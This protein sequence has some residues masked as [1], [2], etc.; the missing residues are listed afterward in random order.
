[1]QTL[2]KIKKASVRTAYLVF[3][4]L[5]TILG[6]IFILFLLSRVMPIDPVL[7]VVGDNASHETYLAAKAAL[8]FDQPFYKQFFIY[9]QQIAKGDL[10]KSLMTSH[11]V[12][13]DLLRVFPA[14]IELGATALLIG[15]LFGIP[16]G[17][18]AAF[19]QN[20]WI[21]KTIDLVTLSGYSIPT[22]WFALICLLL[23]YYHWGILPGIG[24]IDLIYKDFEPTTNFIFFDTLIAGRMDVFFNAL[25]HL[26]LPAGVLGFFVMAYI[27]R[28]T[29]AFTI[30]ELNQQYI[31][32]AK[33]KG[34]S[35]YY[36]VRHVFKNIRAPLVTL[37]ALS[38]GGLLE[39]AVLTETIFAWPGLGLYLTQALQS[40]D[41]NAI[42][43]AVLLIGII[44]MGINLLADMM[45]KFL[46]VRIRE[47]I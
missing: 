41:M 2:K 28:M 20:R 26:I 46:D 30:E 5:A 31:L 39:G 18:L 40:L 38:H 9:F 45:N 27:I 42:L 6:I 12:G 17:I 14:T 47:Y 19:R 32:T 23:F 1:M 44:Y 37:L 34:L 8:G 4:A 10:G 3:S 15:I 29:R 35:T 43:G 24:R 7:S 16:L 21:D 36:I 33:A 22:F 11:R 13:D 25:Q